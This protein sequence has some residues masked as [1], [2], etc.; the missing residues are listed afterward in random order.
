MRKVSCFTKTP[1]IAKLNVVCL[2]HLDIAS[3]TAP[4]SKHCVFSQANT[5]LMSPPLTLLLND[6]WPLT[7]LP[8]SLNNYEE[9]RVLM[10]SV[11]V[12]CITLNAF[13]G[14]LVSQIPTLRTAQ[15]LLR[16]VTK[17]KVKSHGR[18]YRLSVC[19]TLSGAQ[20]N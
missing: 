14:Y 5:W 17:W 2:L 3:L 16:R 18:R 1:L 15:W 4:E 7:S 13:P 8:L 10:P 9:C 11:H 6:Q 12:F 20:R 19:L